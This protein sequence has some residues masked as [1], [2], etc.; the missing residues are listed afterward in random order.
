M[1]EKVVSLEEYKKEKT[2]KINKDVDYIV[3]VVNSRNISEKSHIDSDDSLIKITG[4]CNNCK[5]QVTAYKT[6]KQFEKEKIVIAP[7][8]NCNKGKVYFKYNKK[9]LGNH[10]IND[11]IDFRY[12]LYAFVISITLYILAKIFII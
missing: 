6:L 3:S 12:I 10:F 9:S 5:K 8:K 11:A 7:C 1:K 4:K 2:K